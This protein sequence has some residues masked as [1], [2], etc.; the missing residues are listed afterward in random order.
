MGEADNR[1]KEELEEEQE[2]EVEA[3]EN[4]DWMDSEYDSVALMADT[5]SSSGKKRNLPWKRLRCNKSCSGAPKWKAG[6]IATYLIVGFVG[7][8]SKY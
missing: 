2:I 3:V 1:T 6:L 8:T 7:I 4:D 5:T